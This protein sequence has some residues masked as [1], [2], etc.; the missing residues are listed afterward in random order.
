[1]HYIRSFLKGCQTCQLH[2][3]RS[4]SQRQFESRIN[5]NYIGTSILSC[6]FI[7]MY[8]T[9]TDHKF[10]LVVMDEVTNDLVTISLY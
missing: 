3:V 6:N 2:K 9:T 10:I 4:T 8:R 1:M 5:L 7:Y